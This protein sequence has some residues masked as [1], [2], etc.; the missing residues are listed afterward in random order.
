MVV[1]HVSAVGTQESGNRFEQLLREVVEEARA[2][3]GVIRYDWFRSPD[4]PRQVFVYGEFES[5]E[6]FADYRQGPVVK[7][8]ARDLLPLLES[9]PSFKHFRATIIEQG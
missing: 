8:I 4:V 3:A 7:R 5:E 2:C 6:A 1:I 9:R